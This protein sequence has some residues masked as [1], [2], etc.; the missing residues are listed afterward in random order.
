[1]R[2]VHEHVDEKD[3][4]SVVGGNMLANERARHL[5]WME[6][7]SFVLDADQNS[8]RGVTAKAHANFFAR[9]ARIPV[10]NCVVKSFAER[11]LHRESMSAEATRPGKQPHKRAHARKDSLVL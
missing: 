5:G 10:D 8:F 3:S 11:G 1:M 4:S 7:F 2:F 9:I 6:A